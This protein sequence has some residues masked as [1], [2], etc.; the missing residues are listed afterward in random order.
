MAGISGYYRG[1]IW[2]QFIDGSLKFDSSKLRYL[3]RTPS[4]VGNR[5]GGPGVVGVNEVKKLVILLVS[6]FAAYSNDND[7]DVIRYGGTAT[8]SLDAQLRDG[9]NRGIYTTSKFRDTRWYHNVVTYDSA[10]GV[11]IYVNGVEQPKSNA[12]GGN[13]TLRPKLILWNSILE[14]ERVVVILKLVGM[15]I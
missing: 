9:T 14:Q 2:A 11:K 7:R 3:K 13:A 8:D 12:S 4:T 6:L 1:H 10:V 15:V 5:V